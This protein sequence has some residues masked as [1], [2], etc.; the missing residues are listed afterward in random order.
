MASRVSKNSFWKSGK[1]ACF[2]L[3]ELCKYPDWV[4]SR[5]DQEL[6]III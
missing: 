4:V 1:M 2:I 5:I 3:M 6:L